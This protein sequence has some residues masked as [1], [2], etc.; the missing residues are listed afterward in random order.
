MSE[1]DFFSLSSGL[2][3][4]I[5]P[6]AGVRS[7]SMTLL[8]PA[9]IVREPARFEGLGALWSEMLL[10]G[11]G[12]LDSRQQ[13]DAFDRLGA[14]RRVSQRA[15][16]VS[17]SSRA[18]GDRLEGV[19][20]LIADMVLRPRFEGDALEASRELALSALESL[21]DDPQERCALLARE[22]H[23]AP[24]LNRSGYGRAETLRA[25]RREDV[26]SWW[27][28][29]AVAD[30]SILAIAGDVDP[31]AA[32]EAI[33]RTLGAWGGTIEDVML[34]PHGER[35]RHH[36]DD[37]TSQVQI[38]V[39]HDGPA[40]GDP[41]RVL[42][43]VVQSVLS[44]GMSGRLFSEVREKRGLCYSVH[45]GYT[46]GRDFG[47]VSA[48]VGTTPD[49]ADESLQ[50]LLEELD[51]IGRERDL[52][53]DEFERAVIGMKARTIFSG[54]STQ[55]RASTM[56]RD[57]YCLGRPRTL[58]EISEEIDAVTLDRVL[59]Y[60][61]RRQVGEM[62]IQTLGPAPVGREL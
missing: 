12:D 47:T 35:G 55:A 27:R 32:R 39:L 56:A 26:V 53:R 40:A 38:N 29:L 41:D 48:Y 6:I 44:G 18:M 51:R 58:R 23:Y 46:P 33:E 36:A 42:E 3:V 31:S 60:L 43:H 10:R 62:T 25:I 13:A 61:E 4:A 52:S 20:G 49:R 15:S 30:G 2:R 19:L 1:I 37:E 22:H 50:V 28:R 5:E 34:D 16:F 54:E 9:G 8:T 14:S 21:A 24:P 7:V 11:A 59:A 57:V 45:S 17:I